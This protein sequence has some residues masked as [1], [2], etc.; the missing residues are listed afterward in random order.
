M[1]HHP[2]LLGLP[3]DEHSSFLRGTALGPAAI[4]AALAS[5]STNSWNEDVS[6]VAPLLADQG[7]LVLNGAADPGAVISAK[8]SGLLSRGLTPVLLGGD[9]AVSWPIL[10]SFRPSFPKLTVLHL[11]AHPDLYDS[12][13]GDRQS[14]ACPFARVMEEKL[15][16]RLVQVGIRTLNDHQLSQARRFGVEIIPMRAGLGAAFEMVR[17]LAGPIYVSLD[18]DV[19]D[20]A[21]A[22]GIGHPEP[23]GL[24]TRELLALLQAIPRGQVVGADIVE[25]NPLNDLRDLT[26]RVAAKCIK[27]LA[28]LV[29]NQPAPDAKRPPERIQEA[30]ND[31]EA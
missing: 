2:V 23:G 5:E 17:S 28:G 3:W 12:F 19:L 1:S 25:L 10:R 18:L 6:D 30:V 26:A 13:E 4:R 31:T 9:H 16:D 27:E 29:A 24:T 7:D 15:C 14:H 8:V 21:F 20:P 11:D 22:P